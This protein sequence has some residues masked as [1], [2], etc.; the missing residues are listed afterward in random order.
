MLRGVKVAH[1]GNRVYFQHRKK[2]NGSIDL[3]KIILVIL[4]ISLNAIACEDKKTICKKD[5]L[6][7]LI[8]T[9]TRK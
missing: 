7:N 3:N 4:L 6:G 2:Q 9:T 1:G 8:C 5:A